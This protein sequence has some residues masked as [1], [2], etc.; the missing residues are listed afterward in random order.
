MD[1]FYAQLDN[2]DQV[3]AVSQLASDMTQDNLIAINAF[4]VTLLGKRYNRDTGEFEVVE[5]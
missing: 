5:G 4:D 2:N 1:H 3:I